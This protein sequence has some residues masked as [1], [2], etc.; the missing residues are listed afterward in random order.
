MQ[1]P[2]A[3]GLISTSPATLCAEVWPGL[4]IYLRVSAD[5]KP[6]LFASGTEAPGQGRFKLLSTSVGCRL[7]ID[8]SQRGVY[9]DYLREHWH[10]LI[11]HNDTPLINRMGVLSD[12]M[13]DML[14]TAFNDG[15]TDCIVDTAQQLGSATCEL[16]SDSPIVVEK[17]LSVLHH[18]YGTFTHSTNVSLYC[19]LLAR[20]LGFNEQELEQ[21][22]VGGLL[23]DL[24]KLQI[25]SRILNKPGRLS[26][27]EYRVIM[28]HPSVGY[29]L[30]CKR[31]DL[32]R[33]Q[34]MMVYQHHEK[35]DGSG[36]PVGITDQE[37]HPWAKV[38]T[39]V[40]IYEALTSERPYR[41]A[42]SKSAALAILDKGDGKEF[43]SEVL[44]C[45]RAILKQSN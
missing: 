21:V 1:T 36:Y 30:L 17:L 43:D 4:D 2:V 34:L 16:I 12:V 20:K 9:Q 5:A 22:A 19:V 14:S 40:D 24:G 6:V 7:Y 32:S 41:H 29:R 3:D 15:E 37:I 10:D 33:A 25:D 38:C 28:E 27:S 11:A 45:W 39:V 35:L 42:A 23:H 18:D 13:R 8:K 31:Q 44:K 26:E